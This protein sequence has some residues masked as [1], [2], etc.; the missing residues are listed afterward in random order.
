MGAGVLSLGKSGRDVKLTVR[1][2]I[3]SRV[4]MSGSV[5]LLLLDAFIA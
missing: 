3:V 2:H 5:P 1:F 4:R